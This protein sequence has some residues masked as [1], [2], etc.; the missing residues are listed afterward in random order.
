MEHDSKQIVSFG[1]CWL[2]APLGLLRNTW[3]NLHW[4]DDMEYT[5][6]PVECQS[7]TISHHTHPGLFTWKSNVQQTT[8]LNPKSRKNF[9]KPT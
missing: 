6:C 1:C 3:E 9:E 4:S 8:L 5:E 7:E 2:S